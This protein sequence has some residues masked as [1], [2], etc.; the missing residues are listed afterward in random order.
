MKSFEEYNWDSM[1]IKT[2]YGIEILLSDF[3]P[4]KTVIGKRI[5][6]GCWD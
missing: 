1:Y 3:D 4:H 2:Q 6:A 5:D